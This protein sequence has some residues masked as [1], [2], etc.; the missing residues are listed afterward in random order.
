MS[1]EK[2]EYIQ[3]YGHVY[4]NMRLS[5]GQGSSKSTE[6]DISKFTCNALFHRHNTNCTGFH[7]S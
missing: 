5:E 7:S 6:D 1:K 4:A 2:E 3:K